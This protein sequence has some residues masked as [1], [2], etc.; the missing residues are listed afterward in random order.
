MLLVEESFTRGCAAEA[1]NAIRASDLTLE[2]VVVGEFLVCF[3]LVMING[4]E[5]GAYFVRC[6]EGHK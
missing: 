2:F 1:G 3:L 5:N 6:L 4:K